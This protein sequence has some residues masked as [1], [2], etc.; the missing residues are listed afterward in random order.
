MSVLYLIGQ[1]SHP[2]VLETRQFLAA[3]RIDVRW[4]GAER[5]PLFRDVARGSS[6]LRAKLGWRHWFSPMTR[7]ARR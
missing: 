1:A 6:P 7:P 5:A 3:N 4:V 2:G